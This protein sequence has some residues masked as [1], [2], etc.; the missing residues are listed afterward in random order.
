M[1]AEVTEIAVVYIRPEEG[2]WSMTCGS[3]QRRFA[4]AT[5]AIYEGIQHGRALAKTGPEVWVMWRNGEA[6]SVAWTS[7]AD[8]TLIDRLTSPQPAEEQR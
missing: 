7:D 2:G 3:E 6:W 1:S 4:T 8:R 5:G